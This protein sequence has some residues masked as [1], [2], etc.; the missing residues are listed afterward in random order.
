MQDW[1]SQGFRALNLNISKLSR[2]VE[3]RSGVVGLRLSYS[4]CQRILLADRR[5]ISDP[6][7]PRRFSS[8]P[9]QRPATASQSAAGDSSHTHRQTNRRRSSSSA[10]VAT[11][12]ATRPAPRAHSQPAA[13]DAA[14]AAR[15]AQSPRPAQPSAANHPSSK[16]PLTHP[17]TSP[18]SLRVSPCRVDVVELG[19]RIGLVVRE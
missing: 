5:P 8:R 1:S 12:H 9:L 11:C 18:L 19:R 13:A 10:A 14:A 6:S 2:I 4:G 16:F 7:G 3:L 15:R 17:P